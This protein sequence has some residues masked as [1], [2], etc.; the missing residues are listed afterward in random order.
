[1]ISQCLNSLPRSQ[2]TD[3]RIEFRYSNKLGVGFPQ[4][5]LWVFCKA[6]P[7]VGSFIQAPSTWHSRYH[8]VYHHGSQV[9]WHPHSVA[10]HQY[11]RTSIWSSKFE[12]RDYRSLRSIPL[13]SRLW[14]EHGVIN[15]L[16]L[17]GIGKGRVERLVWG[18]KRKLWCILNEI[19][20]RGGMKR[21]VDYAEISPKLMSSATEKGFWR[22]WEYAAIFCGH[23]GG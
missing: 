8:H 2:R 23:Q 11:F 7:P 10:C 13:L 15:P 21:Y 16:V 9:T 14:D 6:I 12:T 17:V 20:Q 22:A 3:H 4:S 5:T 1:L 19:W 18:S